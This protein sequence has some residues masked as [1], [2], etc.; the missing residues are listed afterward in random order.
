MKNTKAL[1]L[2]IFILISLAVFATNDSTI[3]EIGKDT[4]QNNSNSQIA[5][6][7]QR[8]NM[9]YLNIAN[10]IV[11]WAAVL[12]AVVSIILALAS[13]YGYTQFKAIA[14]SKEEFLQLSEKT[15]A[16]FLKIKEIKEALTKEVSKIKSDM[17]IENN[18]ILEIIFLFNE[19]LNFYNKGL[20]PNAEQKFLA[21]LDL[22]PN[23]YNALCYLSRTYFGLNR[24]IKAEQTIKQ[25]IKAKKEPFLA[26]H[27]LGENQRRLGNNKEAL[28]AFYEAL[29]INESPLTY[30]SRGYVHLATQEYNKA[31]DDFRNSI[32][33]KHDS[34]PLCG[35][36]KALFLNN[37]IP[38]A[39][40]YAHRTIY[41]AKDEIQNKTEFPWSYFDKAFSE[42]II[43]DKNCITSLEFAISRN[44][45]PEVIR[46]QLN[47]YLR[48]SDVYSDKNLLENC[49]LI[50]S[51]KL[52]KLQ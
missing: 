22:D 50:L 46:E 40:E 7:Y 11:N 31:I 38:K 1:L 39:I 21:I 28:E 42:F 26:Y 13:F 44:N 25:A 4:L 41:Q 24:N 5:D 8:D 14:K 36:A 15:E 27:I 51:E 10:T 45:N 12:C 23:D 30:T 19:G 20:L 9:E 18:R 33:I 35:M 29:N 2:L 47:D 37:Q 34:C 32:E 16:E 52:N 17:I 6:S 48:F 3:I 43:K 49:K